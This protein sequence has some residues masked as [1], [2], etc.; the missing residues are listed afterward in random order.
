MRQGREWWSIN[1]ERVLEAEGVGG[2]GGA[3]GQGLEGRRVSIVQTDQPNAVCSPPTNHELAGAAQTA[4]IVIEI[5]SLTAKP[6]RDP[7]H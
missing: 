7:R 1:G 4:S 2:W 5:H 6:I 3:R